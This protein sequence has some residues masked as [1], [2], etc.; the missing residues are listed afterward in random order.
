M[1]V[2]G[3]AGMNALQAFD[4]L[5][6]VTHV[7]S[8][9]DM[10]WLTIFVICFGFSRQSSADPLKLFKAQPYT[11]WEAKKHRHGT[12]FIH[13][14]LHH[15]WFGFQVWHSNRTNIH[16]LERKDYVFSSYQNTTRN[17]TKQQLKKLSTLKHQLNNKKHHFLWGTLSFT[18]FNPRALIGGSMVWCFVQSRWIRE[19]FGYCTTI[20]WMYMFNDA[21]YPYVWTLQIMEIMLPCPNMC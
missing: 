9:N 4:R 15:R 18:S 11:S 19:R 20:G 13:L 12:H 17:F 10:Q 8:R 6:D 21:C 14:A 7:C 1:G 5:L 2:W 3:A 16:I